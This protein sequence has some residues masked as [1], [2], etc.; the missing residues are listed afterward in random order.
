M[1]IEVTDVSE[2]YGYYGYNFTNSGVEVNFDINLA[3]IPF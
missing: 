3:D 1:S 2:E